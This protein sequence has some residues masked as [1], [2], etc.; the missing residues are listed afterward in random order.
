ML[1]TAV[2][3]RKV[4]ERKQINANP[5]NTFVPKLKMSLPLNTAAFK[6]PDDKKSLIAFSRFVRGLPLLSFLPI[7]FQ[8]KV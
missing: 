5:A 2:L 7:F 6:D 4:V 1:G 8:S 3:L